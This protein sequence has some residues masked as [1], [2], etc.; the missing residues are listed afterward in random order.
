MSE[1]SKKVKAKAKAKSSKR[2]TGMVG[3]WEEASDL[4]HAIHQ[5]RSKGFKELDAITPY[6]VH[7]LEEALGLKRSWIP[8]VT[9]GA[10][11]LG[12][13][14]A[15]LFTWW[16]SAVSWPLNVG[17]KPFFSLPAFIPIVFEITILFAALLSVGV[18]FYTC[19]L[20]RINPRVADPSLTS[21][22]FGLFILD[23]DPLYGEKQVAQL[24]QELGAKKVL[25]V[26]NY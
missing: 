12:A 1:M 25:P 15:L 19:G 6:P 22:S 26:S 13:T 23:S 24:F 20:P 11:C 8:Y 4:L 2:L 7:G 3:L 17:G 14:L 9:F 21:H 5:L 18:L 16:T 10:G